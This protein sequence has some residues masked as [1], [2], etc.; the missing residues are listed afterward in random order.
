[1]TTRRARILRL[2]VLGLLQDTPMHGYELRKHLTTELGVFRA[3]S[4]GSLYPCLRELLDEELISQQDPP[5]QQTM[6]L[7]RRSRIIYQL[8][9]EGRQH[10]RRMLAETRPA[11]SDDECFGVHFAL[12]GSTRADVRL[13]ILEERR[14]RLQERLERFRSVTHDSRQRVDPYTYEL[15]RYGAESVEREVRWLSDLI[16]RER[17]QAAAPNT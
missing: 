13:R 17:E 15:R 10:L 6:S 8:T 7:N 1:M 14:E 16:R 5:T 2:A 11:I 4:Y 12:F 9:P 3:F